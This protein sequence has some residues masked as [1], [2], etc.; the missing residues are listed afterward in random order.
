MSTIFATP[1]IPPLLWP[2]QVFP[3][4]SPND[5]AIVSGV[6]K[7]MRNCFFHFLASSTK[8]LLSQTNVVEIGRTEESIPV[9]RRMINGLSMIG[10]CACSSGIS[11]MPDVADFRAA[12]ES[13]VVTEIGNHFP[14]KKELALCSL[15]S[16]FGLQTLIVLQKIKRANKQVNTLVLVDPVYEKPKNAAALQNISTLAKCIFPSLKIQQVKSTETL[17][18]S[19]A[20]ENI[21]VFFEF[22][23][24]LYKDYDAPLNF[25]AQV[26]KYQEI[27]QRFRA[28]LTTCKT[29]KLAISGDLT[30]LLRRDRHHTTLLTKLFLHKNKSKQIEYVYLRDKKP[31]FPLLVHYL[32]D[33]CWTEE[34]TFG[35]ESIDPSFQS[36]MYETM[37]DRFL[38]DPAN[39]NKNF[40][41]ALMNWCT[42]LPIT[43]RIYLP[44]PLE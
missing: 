9:S 8:N 20:L 40:D 34:D 17:S 38:H 7:K 37:R 19:G 3:F 11:R 31:K 30:N 44:Q 36:S 13:I 18:T 24:E 2:D 28:S 16:G 35:W 27:Q 29:P 22:D 14:E 23:M 5:R 39:T 4:L 25:Y 12:F 33:R 6:S 42:Q 1:P 41:E 43:G 10:E 32:E 21:D 15:G 26:R